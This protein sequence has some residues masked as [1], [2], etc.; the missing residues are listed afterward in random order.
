MRVAPTPLYNSFAD[1]HTFINTLHNIFRTVD[2]NKPMDNRPDEYG[3]EV[4]PTSASSEGS[5]GSG[6]KAL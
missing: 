2:V 1:V 6:T 5:A 4:R 3:E